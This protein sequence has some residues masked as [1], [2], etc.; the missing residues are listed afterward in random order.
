MFI[1]IESFKYKFDSEYDFLYEH[2]DQVAGFDEAVD[3]FEEMLNENPDFIGE[4]AMY[5]GDIIRSDRE[6]AA[7]MFALEALEGV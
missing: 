3:A 5:R 1:D 4:F 2:H 7:F 6:A